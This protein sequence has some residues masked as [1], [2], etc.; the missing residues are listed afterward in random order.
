MVAPFIAAFAPALIGGAFGLAGQ[1]MANRE[2]EVSTARQ[3]AFQE[4]MSD[5]QYQRGMEDM[6]KAGLNPILAYKQGGASA[7]SGASYT[8][9]NVGSAGVAGASSAQEMARSAKTLDPDVAQ[10]WASVDLTNGQI[11]RILPAQQELLKMQAAAAGASSAESLARARLTTLEAA[12]YAADEEFFSSPEGANVR[13]A[14]RVVQELGPLGGL[15]KGLAEG[16]MSVR[17]GGSSARSVARP[18]SWA[19]AYGR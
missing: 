1:A 4:R 9:G 8:A 15:V 12:R 7:P 16:F 3:M 2:T 10:K 5:T 19:G 17:R 6:R 11:G 14:G 18:P 13:K